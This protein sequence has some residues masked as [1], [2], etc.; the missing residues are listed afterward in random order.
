MNQF[1]P[2][3]L[4]QF[5]LTQPFLLLSLVTYSPIYFYTVHFMFPSFPSPHHPILPFHAI[6]SLT[7]FISLLHPIAHIH[8]YVIYVTVQ[9]IRY[10]SP[11]SVQPIQFFASVHSSQ[12]IKIQFIHPG[13]FFSFYSFRSAFQFLHKILHSVYPPQFI[14]FGSST[15][16]KS[17]T[18]VYPH[19][20]A[21]GSVHRPHFIK[22]STSAQ[23][24]HS[25]TSIHP[26]TQLIHL[27]LSIEFIHPVNPPQFILLCSSI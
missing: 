4:S 8:H 9:F 13:W 17:S 26:F 25:F 18:S 10:S 11:T 21:F 15:S 22:L 6:I 3:L 1:S 2:L 5:L 23:F 14:H 7:L 19:S 24:R 20:S 16:I 27:N 12:L